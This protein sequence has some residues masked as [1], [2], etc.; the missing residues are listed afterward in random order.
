MITGICVY[1]LVFFSKEGFVCM[2]KENSK[3]RSLCP[4][5][6]IGRISMYLPYLGT[7]NSINGKRDHQKT[8]KKYMW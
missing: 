2:F 5:A 4:M 7:F 8:T 1:R 3:L 6:V